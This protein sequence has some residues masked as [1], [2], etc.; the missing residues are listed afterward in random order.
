[1]TMSPQIA[2]TRIARNLVESELE[3]DRAV[4]SSA[5]L[6]ASMAQARIDSGASADTGQI[7]MMRL[8]RAISA[9]TDARKDVI[10]THSELKKVGQ[11]RAD[12][13]FPDECPN[14]TALRSVFDSEAVLAA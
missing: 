10:Q 12:I 6:L 5:M 2:A 1:M 14:K 7:A 8:V 13:V 9:L 3:I 4:V 11:A